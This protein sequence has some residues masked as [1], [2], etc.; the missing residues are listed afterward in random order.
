VWGFEALLRWQHPDRGLLL[1]GEFLTVAE[2]TGLI[3]PIG[4]WV[5]HQAC[6]QAARWREVHP[7]DPLTIAV[8]LSSRQLTHPSLVDD[9]RGVLAVTGLD[10]ATVV[11]EI[12]ESALMDDVSATEASLRALKGLGVRLA[13]D[14]FGTGYSSLSY[15]RRFPVDILKVDRVFVAGVGQNPED[16]AIVTAVITLAHTLGLGA[17]AEGVETPEQ[18]AELRSLGCD[19]AQ[20]FHLARP[21]PSEAVDDLLASFPRPLAP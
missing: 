18:L 7:G 3:V 10:P 4:D 6:S 11:L 12:T 14:D 8:N 16:S 15:L 9:V 21:V 20:G 19:M 13:V 2:E 17:I 5:L 1:P